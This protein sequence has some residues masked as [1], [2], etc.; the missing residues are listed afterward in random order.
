MYEFP[1]GLPRF[2]CRPLP[3]R[4]EGE[5]DGAYEARCKK[6]KAKSPLIKGW[7][8]K[9]STDPAQIEEWVQKFPG[10][11]WGVPTGPASGLFVID[12]DPLAREW[13]KEKLSDGSLCPKY[14]HPTRRGHHLFFKH[15]DGCTTTAGKLAPGV[16]TRGV[17]GFVIWWPAANVPRPEPRPAERNVRPSFGTSILAVPPAWVL[18][19]LQAQPAPQLRDL[20]PPSS[21]LLGGGVD[22]TLEQGVYQSWSAERCFEGL[23]TITVDDGDYDKWREITWG[24][25]A[26]LIEIGEDNDESFD[27]YH[28]WSEALPG[29][30]DCTC[31]RVW[32]D[33]DPTRGLGPGTF[34]HYVKLA[35]RPLS[36]KEVADADHAVRQRAEAAAV[37][38]QQAESELLTAAQLKSIG[39]LCAVWLWIERQK[40]WWHATGRY[41]LDMEAWDAMN[42]NQRTPPVAVAGADGQPTIKDGKPLTSKWLLQR[43]VAP[44][45]TRYLDFDYRPGEATVL[46]TGSGLA[47][48]LNKWV[49]PGVIPA[50]PPDSFRA[51]WQKYLDGMVQPGEQPAWEYIL[52]TMACLVQRPGY[53]PPV[54]LLIVGSPGTGKSTL[55]EDIMEILVGEPNFITA[56]TQN[57]E[58]QFNSLYLERKV[59]SIPEMKDLSRASANRLKS[60]ITSTRLTINEKYTKEYQVVNSAMIVATSNYDAPV[61]VELG[62]RR[63]VT[64]R[65]AGTQPARGSPRSAMF[66][67][68]HDALKQPHTHAWLHWIF[69]SRDIASWDPHHVPSTTTKH[70]MIEDSMYAWQQDLLDML[71]SKA[72]PFG[73]AWPEHHGFVPAEAIY[74]AVVEQ[75]SGGDRTTRKQI[76]R[77]LGSPPVR[78]VRKRVRDKNRIVIVWKFGA[79]DDE[80]S[81]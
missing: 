19:A 21:A 51:L 45:V 40:C 35:A 18:R 54:S 28:A 43:T 57:L 53:K 24:L 78:G 80:G 44:V 46:P 65:T 59:V 6:L 2:P 33:H 36:F 20:A 76:G 7:Q 31:R 14:T 27:R 3:E 69:H 74:S 48:K 71:H 11:L 81:V 22:T 64:V 63:W 9:A 77:F 5:G 72:G 10:C 37:A 58:S 30:T 56:S 25:R 61:P 15:V 62:D 39:E 16:D 47:P 23:A 17:G 68:L 75:C 32:D 66:R 26:A 55:F 60:I 42:A 41:T 49:D 52:D 1:A 12:I 73:Q 34:Y 38:Q 13:L 79:G 4:E 8:S 50:K 29:H 70:Q 67:L